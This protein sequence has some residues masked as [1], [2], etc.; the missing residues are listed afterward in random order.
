LAWIFV[1][2]VASLTGLLGWLMPAICLVLLLPVVALARLA[3]FVATA[4]FELSQSE[5]ILCIGFGLVWAWHALGIALP[6]TGFDAL[7]YHLPVIRA[8]WHAGGMV[9]VSKYY[10]S[11][12][13]LLS[14]LVLGLGFPFGAEMGV[15]M[16]AWLMAVSTA[17]ITYSMARKVLSR[18][19]SLGVVLLVSTLQVMAWQSTSF[20]VDV[21]K[22][23]WELLAVWALLEV[24][25]NMP[26]RKWFLLFAFGIGA[27]LATKAFSILLLPMLLGAWVMKRHNFKEVVVIAVLV[28]IIILPFWARSWWHT[29][30]LSV[31][32]ETHVAK[33]GEISSAPTLGTYLWQRTLALPFLYYHL[34]VTREYVSPAIL[35]TLPV[36]VFLLWKNN[37]SWK[38]LLN[39]NELLLSA[40]II[41]QVLIWWYVPPLSVRYSLS[42]FIAL[43]VLW[44]RFGE[45]L[46]SKKTLKPQL[47]FVVLLLAIGINLLPRVLVLRRNLPYLLGKETQQQY[48]NRFRDGWLDPH[49]DNWYGK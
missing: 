32:V 44:V 31:S 28:A 25:A 21:A 26:A 20:Y 2:V 10:Q 41:T 46:V 39:Q 17:L 47:A 42:G 36:M 48:L 14:D 33:L 34:T 35:V 22:A 7:W 49:L 30:Y 18:Q 3:S 23:F 19:S 45:I 37:V 16:V 1:A 11:L 43:C 13:P 6:E 8:F 29:G 12:N 15:K 5:K 9:Y 40:F 27:S 24:R 38:K 4:F